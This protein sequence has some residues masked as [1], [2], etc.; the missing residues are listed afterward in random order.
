MQVPDVTNVTVVSDTV[1]TDPVR[2]LNVTGSSES[3]VADTVTVPS[4]SGVSGVGVKVI[5]CPVAWICPAPSLAATAPV[6]ASVRG[7]GL[8]AGDELAGSALVRP[9]RGAGGPVRSAV[10]GSADRVLVAGVRVSVVPLDA[11]LRGRSDRLPPA[12]GD[13]LA[14]RGPLGVGVLLALLDFDFA[15]AA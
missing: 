3:A 7:A 12:V 2:L 1:H 14:V 11:W 5:V 8:L 6:E 10:D 4:S 15:A 13:A 9:A